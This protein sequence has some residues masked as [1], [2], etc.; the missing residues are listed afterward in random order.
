MATTHSYL[1]RELRM[2][3]PEQRD[4][5]RT[6]MV[7]DTADILEMMDRRIE[8]MTMVLCDLRGVLKV[9]GIL[10]PE[11]IH[12]VNDCLNKES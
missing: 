1:A 9:N 4:G 5:E 11:F 3:A 2:I 6:A 12:R 10:P 8:K 7:R